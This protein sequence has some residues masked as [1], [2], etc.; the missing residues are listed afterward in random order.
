MLVGLAGLGRVG[1][2]VVPVG[3]E[4]H[5]RWHHFG[6]I[7]QDLARTQRDLTGSR[8]IWT[9]SYEISPYVVQSDGRGTPNL[10]VFRR[11]TPN[12]AGFSIFSLKNLRKSLEVFGSMLGSGCSSF[13]KGNPPIDPKKSVFVGGDPLPTNGVVGSGSG[14]LLRLVEFR[15]G[16]DSPSSKHYLHKWDSFTS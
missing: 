16:L 14:G 2:W 13:G 11:K 1:F 12:T 3:F 4:F 6:R 5:C 9:R 10:I 15:V 7:R 8:W